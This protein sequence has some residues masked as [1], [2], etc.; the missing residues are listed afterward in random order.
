M[1]KTLG[2]RSPAGLP[3]R[4]RRVP[5]LP[6]LP[7]LP[8]SASVRRRAHARSAAQQPLKTTPVGV[9]TEMG[10][11]LRQLLVDLVVEGGAQRRVGGEVGHDERDDRDR[12]DREQEPQP[13]RHSG[14]SVGASPAR[15]SV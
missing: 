10:A 13:E 7:L 9:P 3:L 15:A 11:L 2:N 5:L 4:R 8:A 6:L 14:R 12:P 1:A